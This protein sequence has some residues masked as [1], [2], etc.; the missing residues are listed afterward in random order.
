MKKTVGSRIKGSLMTGIFALLPV[1]ITAWLLMAM[2]KWA[3]SFMYSIFDSIA[4]SINPKNFIQFTLPVIGTEINGIPGLG[5]ILLIIILCLIGALTRLVF[6]KYAVSLFDQLI[7][8]IP[9]ANKVYFSLRQ[10][11]QTILKPQAENFRRVCLV[12]Y[13]KEGVYSMAFVTGTSA[14]S[15]KLPVDKMVN[16]F[17]P[18]TPNP[19][20][21]FYF[22]VPEKDTIPLDFTIEEAFK[23]IISAGVLTPNVQN[24]IEEDS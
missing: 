15:K 14:V 8:Q 10:I 3:D 1:S 13:P 16:L 2:F 22:I 20:T 7:H 9:I 17:M 19:T 12:Q 21:G 4:P 18:T 23:I 11:T 6:I 5:I 24:K